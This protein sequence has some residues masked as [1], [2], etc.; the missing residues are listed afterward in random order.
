MRIREV[1][2]GGGRLG[3]RGRGP[4]KFFGGRGGSDLRVAGRPIF[5]LWLFAECPN[6]VGWW[7]RAREWAGGCGK[8][9]R[10]QRVCQNGTAYCAFVAAGAWSAVAW[11]CCSVTRAPHVPH[12]TANSPPTRETCMSVCR[13]GWS[14]RFSSRASFR[15][16]RQAC[17]R[18]RPRKYGRS[19]V[20]RICNGWP[21]AE[22]TPWPAAAAAEPRSGRYRRRPSPLSPGTCGA[23]PQTERGAR[24]S[25][26]CAHGNAAAAPRPPVA[27][28]PLTRRRLC[29]ALHRAARVRCC[30]RATAQT[31][32]F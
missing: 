22:R 14:V 8:A 25:R 7:V 11:V 15:G 3:G 26:A 17:V 21:L 9:R 12:N 32:T 19:I 20:I 16:E 28:A 31:A 4:R 27:H 23:S 5:E 1:G 29:S 24:L 10:W 13:G 2:R 6:K 30:L 18:N